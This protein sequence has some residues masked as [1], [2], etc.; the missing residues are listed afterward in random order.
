ME[1]YKMRPIHLFVLLLILV[2]L[3]GASKLPDLAHSLGKS[4]KILKHELKD[5]QGDEETA[6]VPVTQA[7]SPAVQKTSPPLGDPAASSPQTIRRRIDV[8]PRERV[9]ETNMT[10]ERVP[11]G[12][13]FGE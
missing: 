7:P 11:S 1:G 12:D 3:F 10:Q 6:T 9:L 5:L 2:L 8:E 13:S 4:A